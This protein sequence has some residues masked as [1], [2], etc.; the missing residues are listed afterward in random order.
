MKKKIFFLKSQK[1][2]KMASKLVC[3]ID[4][5][6]TYSCVGVFE[7]NRV[8][9]LANENGNRTTPSWVSFGEERLIGDAAK[10][11]AAK[12]SENTIYDAKRF[13]GQ[14]FTENKKLDG[15]VKTLPYEVQN[16]NNKPV[17]Q[18]SFKDEKKKF[19]PEQ[20]S[21]MILEKMKTIAD[22]HFGD[23]VKDCVITV[24]AYF[25]DAQRQ[26]TKD[27]GLIAGLNVL[28]IINE[29][30]AAAIAYGLDKV[31]SGEDKN[32]L[33]FDFGGGT[34]D[35][36]LLNI[37]DG[38]FEVIATSGD[39]HLGGEDL[40][41]LL[42]QYCI[43]EFEKKNRGVKI[44]ENK[45]A[46]SRLHAACERAKRTLSSA[47]SAI[48]EIDA[49]MDGIDF[50]LSISRAKFEDICGEVLRRTMEPVYT[51]LK[52]AKLDKSKVDEIVLVQG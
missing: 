7:N 27:A 40:D 49:L 14:N 3:G 44:R 24:P 23:N 41:N 46:K 13:M 42:I 21:A 34:H 18:V 10:S 31:K 43:Q 16:D 45:R 32:I 51:V 36:S 28:R 9:I 1:K 37:S 17:F 33:V 4:L 2:R 39:T 52:D 6:T 29:P 12:N 48:I 8:E 22:S 5:G 20:I 35:V 19:T 15:F 50:N 26:A 47:T 38:V 30:T 25:N 11:S